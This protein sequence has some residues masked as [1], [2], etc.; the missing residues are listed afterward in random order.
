MILDGPLKGSA[1]LASGQ[2]CAQPGNAGA[3]LSRALRLATSGRQPTFGRRHRAAEI[4]PATARLGNLLHGGTVNRSHLGLAS[5]QLTSQILRR[6]LFIGINPE[7]DRQLTE[8]VLTGPQCM[9]RREVVGRRLAEGVDDLGQFPVDRIEVMGRFIHVP[10]LPGC[11]AQSCRPGTNP[12]GGEY[13]RAGDHQPR[14]CEVAGGID[15]E[16]E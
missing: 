4:S 13:Q 14:H 11:P 12:G 7:L 15:E 5:G 2:D 9:A 1:L 6:A 10:K 3:D 16:P 8:L